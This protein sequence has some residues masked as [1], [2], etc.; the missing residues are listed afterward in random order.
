MPEA[1]PTSAP[2][3]VA[4]LMPDLIVGGGQHLLLRNLKGMDPARVH[5]TVVCVNALGEMEPAYRQ[6]G[7]PLFC[8]QASGKTGLLAAAS[9][10]TRLIRDQGINLIHT[11]NTVA[12]RTVGQL[13]AWRT[14]LP[15]VNS[16]HSEHLPSINLSGPKAIPRR[17]VRS[18]GIALARRTV[19]HVIPVSDSVRESWA[20]YLQS[21]GIGPDRITVINPG[22]APE[23][24]QRLGNAERAYLRREL[25]LDTADPV[26]INVGRLNY[27]KGQHWLIP[28]MRDVL[29]AHP[30]A[31][32]ILV[33]DGQDRQRL[34]QS[35]RDLNLQATVLMLGQRS[36]V[37]ALLNIADLFVFPSL[38]EGFP[39][40]VLEA[41]AARLPIVAF[42]LPSFRGVVDDGTSAALVPLGDAPAFTTAVLE[43]LSDRH[44]MSAMGQSALNVAHRY[45]QAATSGALMRIYESLVRPAPFPA[46][47]PASARPQAG[48]TR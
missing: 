40:A 29:R 3:R 34:E 22:L 41:M 15:V 30:N 7:L 43:V 39:L 21:M 8:L 6:A 44:R 17:I 38:T 42:G 1:G 48:A 35:T 25:A 45:T 10:L 4:H 27:H 20:P 18:L 12:D 23:R 13:A 5:N 19:D 37:T 28:M 26:L 47:H 46:T 11:N 36:D 24:F 2:V 32:L 16:L 9:K 31:K 14:G 33:G